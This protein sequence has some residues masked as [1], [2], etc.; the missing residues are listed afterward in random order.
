MASD[1]THTQWPRAPSNLSTASTYTTKA[2]SSQASKLILFLTF[3]VFNKGQQVVHV[4][5]QH[6]AYIHIKHPHQSESLLDT[7]FKPAASRRSFF[8]FMH[9][10]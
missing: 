6:S 4:L 5:S 9:K 10:I 2:G 7:K 8:L 1:T 3:Y